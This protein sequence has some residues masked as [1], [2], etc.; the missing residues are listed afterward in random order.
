M[1]NPKFWPITYFLGGGGNLLPE[2]NTCD[3]CIFSLFASK[4]SSVA[5]SCRYRVF[6]NPHHNSKPGQYFRRYV[7]FLYSLRRNQQIW[8]WCCIVRGRYSCIVRKYILKS[9]KLFLF[10][11]KQNAIRINRVWMSLVRLHFHDASKACVWKLPGTNWSFTIF[12]V[13]L[14]LWVG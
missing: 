14:K 3:A 8:S 2:N 1:L 7:I 11:S 5:V 4:Q 12:F 9:D 6:K 10:V 13:F